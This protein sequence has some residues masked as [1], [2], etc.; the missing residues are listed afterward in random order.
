MPWKPKDNWMPDYAPTVEEQKAYEY[1]VNNDIRISPK[2]ISGDTSRYKISIY[3]DGRWK[4]SP[5]MPAKEV[6]KTLYKY[7]IFYHKKSGA[8]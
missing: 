4:D 8:L 6:W 2:G 1:C 5:P 7:C 3:N